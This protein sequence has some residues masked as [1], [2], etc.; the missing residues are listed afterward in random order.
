MSLNNN[1]WVIC[2]FPGVG[3]TQF[4]NNFRVRNI[5]LGNGIT[6]L[7][8]DSTDFD[9]DNFPE[10][11]LKHIQKQVIT[12]TNAILVSTHKEVLDGLEEMKIN[13]LIVYPDIN[14]KNEYLKR[15]IHRYSSFDFIKK[16]MDHWEE[17]IL[18]IEERKHEKY[19]LLVKLNKNEV[20]ADLF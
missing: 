11:Y 16:V 4:Y 6:S 7:D 2:G 5:T 3:K 18:A 12:G 20:L 15:Y 1:S 17:W 8:S 10:N 13:H 14:L 9:K 19:S